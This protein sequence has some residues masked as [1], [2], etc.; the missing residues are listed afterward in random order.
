M[1]D[2]GAGSNTENQVDRVT[3]FIGPL[4]TA[5]AFI[6]PL[7]TATAFIG[8][9]DTATAFIGPL[10]TATA[11]NG[12]LDTAT[13]FN[14]PLDTATAF[15]GPLDTAT[16]F[17]GPLDTAT[18]FN[19]PLDT[20]T[21]FNGP[22]DTATAFNGPLDTATA[23]SGPLDTATAF[24]GPLDRETAFIR[25]GNT[26]YGNNAIQKL[27][28]GNHQDL[29]EE[30][31]QDP[32]ILLEEQLA[33]GQEKLSELCQSQSG[34]CGEEETSVLEF[35]IK[36]EKEEEH[37]GFSQAGCQ[38]STVKQQNPLSSEFVMDER[39]S[40]L[41]S[42][43]VQ[44]NDDIVIETDFPDFSYVA[45]QY[46][47][48]FPDRSEAQP[49]PL[50]SPVEG[51]SKSTISP[52]Q[53]PCNGSMYNKV[54][55][56]EK[57]S[58]SQSVSSS[59]QCRPQINHSQQQTRQRD[60]V[61]SQRNNHIPPS[62][63]QDTGHTAERS[64]GLGDTDR[65]TASHLGIRLNNNTFTPG[66]LRSFT[67]PHYNTKNH[68]GTA[69]TEKVFSCSQCGKSFSRLSYLKIHQRSH[70]GERPFRC[71]VCGKS[72]HCSSHLTIH[73]RIHTGERPYSCATCGKRFTQQSSLKTHQS[74]HSG[75]R[76]YGCSQCGKT[77][78]LLHHLKRHRIIHAGYS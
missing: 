2:H 51:P 52:L 13:A 41:W 5:T 4:D 25:Q 67:M 36:T 42:S 32:L 26:T 19:G 63:P 1:M 72:F 34:H 18:A 6:G 57:V 62:R 40:Q 74:V 11:F 38:R 47:E 27:P 54:F 46:S 56:K 29:E 49:Q 61:F 30:E 23:F 76:P 28:I 53:R 22:L 58:A 16:A 59:F 35:V 45:E 78:T 50:S 20:A 17:N 68:W 75:E 39:D 37:S 48:S 14:G 43:I 64:F 33:E 12:P 10:D 9:L 44:G 70:T 77:F 60:Q 7:D 65:P 31:N 69:I 15:N 21:A 66:G 8:P 3:E 73:H 55:Q 71:T 24:S